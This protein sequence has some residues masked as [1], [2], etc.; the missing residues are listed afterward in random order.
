MT[1]PASGE[2]TVDWVHIRDTIQVNDALLAEIRAELTHLPPEPRLALI[3]REVVH[4][5]LYVLTGLP[6]H[7]LVVVAE[8]YRGNGGAVDSSRPRRGRAA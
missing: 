8:T 7:P 3:A 6:G 1:M 4:D 2:I 5:P